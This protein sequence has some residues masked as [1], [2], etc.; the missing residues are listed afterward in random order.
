MVKCSC[1]RKSRSG[2]CNTSDVHADDLLTVPCD[3]Q[4]E[5]ELRNARLRD[6]LSVEPSRPILPYPTMV[7]QA[8]LDRQ[9]LDFCVR[10]ERKLNDWLDD[11]RQPTKNFPSMKS[12][13][14][15]LLHQLAAHYQLTAESVDQ[16]PN[17]SVRFIR[18]PQSAIPSVSLSSATRTYVSGKT[19]KGS[20]GPTG[21]DEMYLLHFLGL[22]VQPQLSMNDVRMMMHDWEGKFKLNW[23]DDDHAIAMFDERSMR[24]RAK[25][26]LL[27]RGLWCDDRDE[28]SAG[29][30][31][32]T[33]KLEADSVCL[34]RKVAINE[35]GQLQG[36]SRDR[37]KRMLVT[38]N[39]GFTAVVTVRRGGSAGHGKPPGKSVAPAQSAIRTAAISSSSTVAS[40]M[41][42]SRRP[43]V[44][45]K[46]LKQLQRQHEENNNVSQL[47]VS[48]SIS[49]QVDLPH[50][51]QRHST[52]SREDSDTEQRHIGDK[53]TA[54]AH[55]HSSSLA[56]PSAAAV[57]SVA[58][59]ILS[60][61]VYTKPAPQS[62]VGLY[63][64][65]VEQVRK[66]NRWAALMDDEDDDEQEESRRES[67][68]QKRAGRK[69]RQKA[70]RATAPL[71]SGV[72]VA[73]KQ[74]TEESEETA[75]AENNDW[76]QAAG[77]SLRGR[78]NRAGMSSVEDHSAW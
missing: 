70:E 73:D 42:P 7:M 31:D 66:D 74:E 23:L 46:G 16:E 44:T 76:E 65:P 18:Q 45:L 8:V 29:G 40:D 14:R 21:V 24:D 2:R 30:T 60:P 19:A 13:Q 39:D 75:E 63:T 57:S 33:G 48:P 64:P 22:T 15:W 1:G 38:G 3:E 10:S 5:L 56:V 77:Q 20:A 11:S 27:A 67:V 34:F 4:C 72:A 35:S 25:E 12:D 17:R 32:V 58:S 28:R 47:P 36:V 49:P 43:L 51:V 69:Q 68:R 26:R 6:I 53:Y 37:E 52:S 78:R 62:V 71:T 9:L 41:A 61:T 50:S 54:A 55:V 59:S